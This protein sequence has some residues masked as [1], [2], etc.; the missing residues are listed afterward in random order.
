MGGP[1]M[2]PHTPHRLE[3]PGKAVALLDYRAADMGGPDT[4]PQRPGKA[5]A[6]LESRSSGHRRGPA[7]RGCRA[8]VG[9]ISTVTLTVRR[10]TGYTESGKASPTVWVTGSRSPET[11]TGS[12]STALRASIVVRGPLI[13]TV[14]GSTTTGPRTW[15]AAGRPWTWGTTCTVRV[16]ARV[17]RT[18]A[19][20][21]VSRVTRTPGG[22]CT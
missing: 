6:L 15:S 19:Q 9:R 22:A 16:A 14:A 10:S 11:S 18:V 1:D 7:A 8:V 20:A 17:V 4:A 13:W 21:G 2:A 12:V 5:V 3:R